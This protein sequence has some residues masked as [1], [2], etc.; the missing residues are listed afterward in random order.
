MSDYRSDGHVKADCMLAWAL[1]EASSRAR[2]DLRC[3]LLH[4]SALSSR[5]TRVENIAK[6]SSRILVV[7]AR[8]STAM[9][10]G[11]LTG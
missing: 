5:A 1:I 11:S 6:I 2:F 8:K 7:C 10:A 3:L 4:I 9:K